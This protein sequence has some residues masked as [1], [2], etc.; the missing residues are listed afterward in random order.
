M[1]ERSLRVTGLP[2]SDDTFTG[3]GDQIDRAVVVD[4]A[5]AVRVTM[6]ERGLGRGM[7]TGTWSRW[8]GSRWTGSGGGLDA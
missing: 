4:P 5:E 2:G 1:G 3:R 8:A 7:G 6:S